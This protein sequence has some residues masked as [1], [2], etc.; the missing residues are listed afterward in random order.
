MPETRMLTRPEAEVIVMEEIV[1]LLE[2]LT[3]SAYLIDGRDVP[4]AISVP[5]PKRV[6]ERIVGR[7]MDGW[8]LVE[9][10]GS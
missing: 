7:L 9:T 1:D 3:Q 5:R 8:N 2:R 10:S 4:D 6:V